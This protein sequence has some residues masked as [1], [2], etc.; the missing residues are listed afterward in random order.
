VRV[1]AQ[2]EVQKATSLMGWV[3]QN[4]ADSGVSYEQ[5]TSL[6]GKMIGVSNLR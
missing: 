6:C 2:V 1:M 3:A 5:V 4:A